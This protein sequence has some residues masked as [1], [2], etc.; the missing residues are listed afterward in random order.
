MSFRVVIY[1]LVMALVTYLLRL[2]PMLLV[3]RKIENKLLNKFL[4]Y[5]PYCALAAMTFPAVLY[6]TSF[7]LSAVVGTIVALVLS[8][9]NRSLLTVSV[10][11]CVAVYLCELLIPYLPFAVT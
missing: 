9:F 6:S 7:I 2:L 4:Y 3:K 11:A 10:C 8:Y 1:I 5:V